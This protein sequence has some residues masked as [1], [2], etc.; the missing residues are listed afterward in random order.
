MSRRPLILPLSVST[1]VSLVGGKAAGLARLL[2]AGFAVPSGICV[3]TEAYEWSLQALGVSP[4]AEW[5]RVCELSETARQA[6][7]L[8]CQARIRE[9]DLSPLE[10]QWT[11][12]L[13]ALRASATAGW[14]VRSSATN[15]DV[16]ETSF[17][18]IYRTR[19]GVSSADLALTVKDLWMAVWQEHVVQY[20]R[21]RTSAVAAPLMAVV[22]QP[23][24]DARTSGVA[25]SIH[26]VT[27]RSTQVAI[28]AVL[29]LASRLVEGIAM[30]DQYVVET[31]T[32]GEP[33]RIRGRSI[34]EK[35]ERLAV[36]EK[37]LGSSLIT[38][39]VGRQSSLSDEALFS[40]ARVTKQVEQTW[41][42]PVDLEWVFD[43]Q[44]LWILQARPITSVRPTSDLTNDD[45]EWS[46]ANFKETMPE[47]PSPLGL[48]FLEFFLEAYI[49]SHY[50][51][52]GC[53]I[54]EGLSSVRVL[55]GRPYLNVTLL[56]SLVGQLGGEPSLNAEH[57]GGESLQVVPDVTRVGRLAFVRA[58][59]LMLRELR[60]CVKRGPIWFAEMKQQ[61][62]RYQPDRIQHLSL[63]ELVV[64]YEALGRW[65]A[66]HEVTFGIAAGV[67]Q[68]LQACSRL[69]PCWLG[70]DWRGLLNA[71]L[72]GQ[73]T[74]ISAQ[75]I[76]RLAELAQ[77]ARSE[78]AAYQWFLRDHWEPARFREGLTG[79]ECLRA[80]ERYLEDYGHRGVGESDIMSPRMAEQ[81]DTILAVLRTQLRAADAPR[82]PDILSRQEQCRRQ[83]LAEIRRRLGW[84]MDRWAVFRWWYR[85]LTRLF[86]LREANRHHLMYYA[87]ASRYLLLQIGERLAAEG[88]LSAADD[89]FFVILDEQPRLLARYP[90]DWKGLVDRRRAEWARHAVIQV[91]D[92]IRDWT[93]AAAGLDSLDVAPEGTLRGLPISAGCVTGPARFLR[94]AADWSKVAS[95][96]VLVAP[97][98]DPGMAPLFGIAGGLI[99]EMGGTLSHG[100]IIA[101]EYGL[102]TVANVE[103]A[104]SR[105]PEGRRVTVDA[106]SGTIT[107][108]P[109]D[110]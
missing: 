105:I 44:T 61:A 3:T 102:P 99:A 41:G 43:A 26:P 31:S 21:Q 46:R 10:A 78:P 50:R 35:I 33:V 91:P 23:M 52:L 63:A 90:E 71:A 84:R 76:I 25:Y 4:S 103:R 32:A 36:T 12:P 68:A 45:C 24:I 92:T 42:V 110:A 64:Q 101:R 65:L 1:D 80:F 9:A 82:A 66:R 16:G 95:G 94:S 39:D 56:H 48:S 6:A 34:A 20:T 27:G 28:N 73:G 5:H 47:V 109:Q 49:L 74:V 55:Y 17:A 58:A 85:R 53:R 59:W 87:T 79:T 81:P 57:M 107:I 19:L 106:G 18:G 29:G 13:Q 88:T 11:T 7:L 8:R 70:D 97:V 86:A 100:A 83:A 75:Q 77:T 54:P 30:P 108:E 14:A 93:L 51:R 37:G 104:M 96:D 40:L 15:E 22:I 69:L 89:I 98:I 67:G 60:R 2:A 62:A 72:Q 38:G